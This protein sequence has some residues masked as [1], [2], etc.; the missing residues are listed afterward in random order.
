[1]N[2]PDNPATTPPPQV[3][4]TEPAAMSTGPGC[5][6]AGQPDAS[7]RHETAALALGGS[8]DNSR[9]VITGTRDELAATVANLAAQLD[10]IPLAGADPDAM[11]PHV[12]RVL[13]VSTA[14]LPRSLG[15]DGLA[16][17]AGITAHET[18]QGWL[19]W[20][21]EDPDESAAGEDPPPPEVVLNL[22]RYARN[23][24]GDYILFDRD[25]FLT[26]GLPSWDW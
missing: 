18:D 13:D 26:A 15:V 3:G 14:H 24:R 16:A 23:L 25:G 8:D 2:Q 21:P 1:V 6:P 4:P 22:Q 12:R 9:L 5:V 7:H 17:V 11:P 19:L 20:V 10:R